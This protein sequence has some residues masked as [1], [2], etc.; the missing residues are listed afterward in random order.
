M[1]A[2][3][4][5]FDKVISFPPK[6][7]IDTNY[8][9][10]L[11]LYPTEPARPLY[12]SCKSFYEKMR[13][14]NVVMYTSILSLQEAIYIILYKSGVCQ[15]MKT[16][17][18]RNGNPFSKPSDF[19]KQLP[20]EF[21]KSYKKHFPGVIDFM[22]FFY[23]LHI[24][25]AFPKS[26]IISTIADKSKRVTNYAL[27]LLKKYELDPMDAFHVAIAKCLGIDHIVST[28]KGLKVI[29]EIKLFCYN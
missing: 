21:I 24:R 29:N 28:D 13:A 26:Y 22:Q 15:D 5:R 27:G 20:R 18:G 25:L 12:K 9:L 2:Q 17:Q 19:R 11:K 3:V 7:Y 8:L 6:A 1:P 4:Q 23:N 16:F 10:Y 14:N